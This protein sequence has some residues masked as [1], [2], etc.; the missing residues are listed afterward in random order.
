MLLSGGDRIHD[1]GYKSRSFHAGDDEKEFFHL[2]RT[3]MLQLRFGAFQLLPALEGTRLLDC[4]ADLQEAIAPMV[5]EF[6]RA[7]EE[8]Y[9]CDGLTEAVATSQDHWTFRLLHY[10]DTGLLARP[11]VDRGGFTMHLFEDVGGGQYFNFDG[12]WCPWP[13]TSDSTII[14]PS[15]G[16]QRRDSLW[17][18][19]FY[20]TF[21]P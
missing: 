15:M 17:A 1:V 18:L 11:H 4:L 7:V 12:V 21:L 16:L 14:F 5:T 20:N 13:I 9:R 10:R 6:A 8:R 3:T 19:V 2:V